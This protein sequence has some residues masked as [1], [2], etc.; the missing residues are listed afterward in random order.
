[1]VA[2]KKT[3]RKRKG[4]ERMQT[5]NHT[6]IGGRYMQAARRR[7][8]IRPKKVGWRGGGGSNNGRHNELNN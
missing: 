3:K 4:L 5:E 6:S 1:M 8:P 2:G 7:G